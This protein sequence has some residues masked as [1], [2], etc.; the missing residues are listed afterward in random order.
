MKVSG[1][2]FLLFRTTI[3]HKKSL[4]VYCNTLVMLSKL[5]IKGPSP[6]LILFRLVKSL[7]VKRDPMESSLNS[8]W[9]P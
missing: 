9:A 4:S 3:K 6:F 2:C 8:F 7:I 1:V 5:S